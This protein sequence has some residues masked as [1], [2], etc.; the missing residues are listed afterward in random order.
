MNPMD[1]DQIFERVK[2]A[3]RAKVE[4]FL[5]EVTPVYHQLNWEWT[6]NGEKKVPDEEDVMFKL[7]NLIDA[8]KF[9]KHVCSNANTIPLTPKLQWSGIEEPD[10]F[11]ARGTRINRKQFI[12]IV[13]FLSSQ[14]DRSNKFR[15]RLPAAV[16]YSKA[17]I[18]SDLPDVRLFVPFL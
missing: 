10:L 9:D 4:A 3:L 12:G 6:I 7:Y 8:L 2:D 17:V 15:V 5:E 16:I 13:E 1:N 14:T 11:R 18:R